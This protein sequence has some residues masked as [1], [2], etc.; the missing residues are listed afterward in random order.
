MVLMDVVLDTLTDVLKIIPF[1][2]VIYLF[3][4][5]LEHVSVQLHNLPV[6]SR[7]DFPSP[8]N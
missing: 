5:F 4:E 6:K 8:H 2:F 1:L 3:L 7:M